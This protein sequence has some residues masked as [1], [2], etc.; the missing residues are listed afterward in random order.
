M[1][2]P[3]AAEAEAAS[4]EAAK[5]PLPARVEEERGSL[6]P[7]IPDVTKAAA[8]WIRP[9]VPPIVA[10][11]IDTT[12]HPLRTARQAFEEVEEI[13]FSFKRTHKVTVSSEESPEPSQQSGSPTAEP[14]C[15]ADRVE[16]SRTAEARPIGLSSPGRQ[17]ELAGLD[18]SGQL[19]GR[20]VPRALPR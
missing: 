8:R 9:L 2:L 3:I 18:D 6:I 1:Y 20:D 7:S 15:E 19:R 5:A 12:T 10:R 13:T 16:W 17:S 14:R 11:A 4:L